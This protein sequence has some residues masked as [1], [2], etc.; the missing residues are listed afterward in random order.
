LKRLVVLLGL[1]AA[2]AAAQD[3]AQ[4]SSTS[5]SGAT[6][7][8]SNV[9]TS[10]AEQLVQGNYMNLFAFANGVYDTTR[11]TLGTRNGS[12]GSVGIDVGGGIG[13]SH[14]FSSALLSVNYRGEYRDYTGGSLASGT[15]Q[16]LQIMYAKR[17]SRRWTLSLSESGAILLY[18]QGYYTSENPN[19]SVVNNPFSPETRYSSSSVFVSYQQS[20]RL[21]YS[22]G[23]S[24]FI[25]RYNYSGAIGSTG[26]IF[27]GAVAYQITSRTN[28]GATFSH[29]DFFYTHSFGETHIN[30]VFGDVRHRFGRNWLA[31]VSGGVTHVNASGTIRVPVTF[32]FNGQLVT[33]YEIGHYDTISN[34]PTVQ[35]GLSKMYKRYTFSVSGGRGV[36]P[37]NGN[38][39]TSTRTSFGGY[40]SRTFRNSNISAAGYYNRLT[41]IANKVESDYSA[42]SLSISYSRGI[43]RHLF[44]NLGYSYYRYGSYLAYGASNDNRFFFGVNFSSK[45]LPTTIF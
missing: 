45:N 6:A 38:L 36:S 3:T 17:L 40:A 33:G 29:D 19:G 11:Q 10:L 32:I 37:G 13:I 18:G 26:G 30:G 41:S 14:E 31:S 42:T 9:I 1:C 8:H 28:I 16:Y 24:L 2:A 5:S 12:A 20:H 39:I 34:V 15:T 7:D 44:G 22:I 4:D 27:S 35:A 21:T 43:I 23:G 25:N